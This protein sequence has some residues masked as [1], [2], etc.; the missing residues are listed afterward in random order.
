MLIEQQLN[1][2]DFLETSLNFVEAEEEAILNEE[3]NEQEALPDNV[4]TLKDYRNRKKYIEILNRA[5]STI[6]W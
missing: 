3:S 6:A 4:I 2:F 1:I 5:K